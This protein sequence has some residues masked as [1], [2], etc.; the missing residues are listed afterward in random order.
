[1]KV[2]LLHFARTHKPAYCHD[3]PKL[4]NPIGARQ[5][6]GDGIKSSTCLYN[7]H[8]SHLIPSAPTVTHQRHSTAVTQT[9]AVAND[10]LIGIVAPALLDKLES[11]SSDTTPPWKR[12]ATS[13]KTLFI[14]L[15][16]HDTMSKATNKSPKISKTNRNPFLTYKGRDYGTFSCQLRSCE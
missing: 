9:A 6:M 13:N 15:K 11:A 2:P 10:R 4:L 16:V 14:A 7:C 12:H 5:T 8:G 3:T 1:M